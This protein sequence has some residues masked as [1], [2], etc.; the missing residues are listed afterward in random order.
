MDAAIDFALEKAGGL[1]NTE[2]LGDGGERKGE[3]F[4][5]LGDG[6]FTL[7]EAGEDGAAGGIGEGGEGGVERSGR[8]IV[9]HTV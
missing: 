5:N 1:E 4:G 7:R 2:M 9:N 8:E 6:G 3:R